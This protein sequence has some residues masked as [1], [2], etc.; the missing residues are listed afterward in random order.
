MK[1]LYLVFFSV[2]LAYGSP[3]FDKKVDGDELPLKLERHKRMYFI[4]GEENT[5]LQVSFKFPLFLNSHFFLSYTEMGFW[6]LF[7]KTSNPFLDI[8]HNPEL[9]YRWGLSNDS[10]L[11]L[12]IEHV[13]N[14]KGGLDSRSWNTIYTQ[15]LKRWD[16]N[17]YS[18]LKLFTLFDIE[19]ANE[20]IY[21]YIGFIDLELGVKD[22]IHSKFQSNELFFRYRPGGTF[23]S[24]RHET[25]EVGLKFKLTR[26]KFFEHF[27]VSYYNGF[28]E[29]Q[30]YYNKTVRAL[31]LGITF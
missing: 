5:K 25:V 19:A 6:E 22:I 2:G 7:Q 24:Y 9:F 14:G 10:F 3:R 18:T 12:G 8:T 26:F 28:A 23:T 16:E 29:N 17:F 27:L 13:S 31:R 30:L 4:S 15:A 1:F 20:D 21:D 11:D